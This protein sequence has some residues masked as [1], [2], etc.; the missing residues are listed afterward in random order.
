MKPENAKYLE[1][2]FNFM[3]RGTGEGWCYEMFGVECGD[4][5][6]ELIKNLCEEIAKLE[7]DGI[8]VAQ[9][10]E[11]FGGLRFYVSAYPEQVDVDPKAKEKLDALYN[12][13]DK[14][15]EKSNEICENCG[16]P[17]SPKI[18]KFWIQTLCDACSGQRK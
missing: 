1:D 2:N 14:A 17:G 16:S 15:E 8:R 5:W 13:I 3:K 6:F 12:L 18:D 7:I 10:K 11:K 4:G 9:V